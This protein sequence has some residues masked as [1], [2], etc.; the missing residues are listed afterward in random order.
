MHRELGDLDGVVLVEGDLKG[1]GAK[2]LVYSG[3]GLAHLAEENP[4]KDFMGGPAGAVVLLDPS[5]VGFEFPLGFELGK[6]FGLEIPRGEEVGVEFGF[7]FVFER[8][9]HL[10]LPWI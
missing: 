8:G 5:D 9:A 4:V 7:D 6:G 3:T 1:F 10:V 2:G